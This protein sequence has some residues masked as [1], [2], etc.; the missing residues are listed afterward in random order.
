MKRSFF[1]IILIVTATAIAVAG[2]IEGKVT[3][4]N[5]VVYVDVIPGKT[6]PPLQAVK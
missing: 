6:F 5:S 4:G 2:S 1:T 3:P